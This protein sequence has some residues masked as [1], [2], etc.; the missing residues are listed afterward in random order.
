MVQKQLNIFLSA[1]IPIEGRDEKYSETADVIAIR[2]SVLALASVALPKYKLIWGGH[3]SITPL[4]ANVLLHAGV[5][6]QDSVTLYQSLYFEQ[7]FPL[8]NNSVAHIIKTNNM[9]EK[10]LSINEMRKHMLGDNEFYAGI[11][12]GG[13]EGVEDEYE[14]FVQMHPNAKTLPIASTGAAAKIIYDKC[15]VDR[16][17]KLYTNLAY[18]S[19]FK[20]FLN[21]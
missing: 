19:L 8:E 7:F 15:F 14:M 16:V 18:T 17:S 5:N 20:D 1:S 11:F 4:I 6:I 9:G 10:N 2:D 3:P 12:I 21:L 13:M